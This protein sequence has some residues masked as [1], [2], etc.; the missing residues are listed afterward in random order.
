[1]KCKC[2]DE[3]AKKVD[4]RI[5]PDLPNH[6]EYKSSVGGLMLSMERGRILTIPI[7]YEY[8]MIKKDKIP[9]KNKTKKSISIQVS[10]CPF[11]GGKVGD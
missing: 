10:Y 7:N 1:M 11:C 2:I 4:E 5:V 8:R 3:I 9:A 6:T